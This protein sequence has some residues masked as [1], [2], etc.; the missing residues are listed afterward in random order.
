M[1]GLNIRVAPRMPFQA[2]STDNVGPAQVNFAPFMYGGLVG[3]VSARNPS[4]VRTD[5]FHYL[6]E[7]ASTDSLN[8]V[9]RLDSSTCRSGDAGDYGR[10]GR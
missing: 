4:A 9:L 10:R 1:R 2:A 5:V 3:L 8:N 7:L 6:A